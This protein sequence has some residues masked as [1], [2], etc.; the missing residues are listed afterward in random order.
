MKASLRWVII[1]Q[2][3]ETNFYL[4]KAIFNNDKIKIKAYKGELD[5]LLE[6]ILKEENLK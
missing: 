2:I 5:N 3:I 1:E 6:F 4:T